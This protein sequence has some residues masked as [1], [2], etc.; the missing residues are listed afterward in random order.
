MYKNYWCVLFVTLT[1]CYYY[2]VTSY[3]I[4]PYNVDEPSKSSSESFAIAEADGDGSHLCYGCHKH[5]AEATK[6]T[7]SEVD[8]T[9]LRIEYIKQQIL[10]KLRLKEPP[11]GLMSL[12]DLPKPLEK[13]DALLVHDSE[14]AADEQYFAKTTQAVLFPFDVMEGCDE[15]RRTPAACFS[16]QLP[17]DLDYQNIRSAELWL[18]KRPDMFD[19]HNQTFVIS[20]MAHWDPKHSFPRIKPIAILETATEEG[21]IRA[22]IAPSVRE[23]LQ[24][25][26][27]N[28]S[29]N[30]ACKT[31]G[32]DVSESPISHKTEHKLFLVIS[33]YFHQNPTAMQYD[34]SARTGRNR[35]HNMNCNPDAKECCRE[36]LYIS[37][38]DIGWSD[39][40]IFPSGYNAYFCRGSCTSAAAVTVSGSHYNSIIR[41]YLYQGVPENLRLELLPCCTATQF[42]PLQLL[43]MDNNNTITL[44]MLPNMIVESC[45]C[46]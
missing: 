34:A 27:Y 8:L 17:Y 37:F 46:L 45:G 2:A 7:I 23:W 15:D 20:E 22:D 4:E 44:K 28:H 1:Y 5:T 11:K 25:N 33:T 10:K 13:G 32:M 24:Y 40:I 42:Q 41:A 6:I 21:W 38:K 30:V 12:S 36:N 3:V 43:Y 35:R 29:I 26:E 18:Y 19:S 16:L 31:C 39:W 9:A 14:H